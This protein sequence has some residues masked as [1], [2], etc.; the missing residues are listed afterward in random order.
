MVRPFS[1]HVS[2]ALSGVASGAASIQ[3]PASALAVNLIFTIPRTKPYQ[4]T[5]SS[6]SLHLQESAQPCV[7][8]RP[9]EPLGH[10]GT[11]T[12]L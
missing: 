4:L 7:L 5:C 9:E 10:A 12:V 6:G 3:H 2:G 11:H 1:D 8:T